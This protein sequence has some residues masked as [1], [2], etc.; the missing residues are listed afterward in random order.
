MN[1]MISDGLSIS[2]NENTWG[3]INYPLIIQSYSGCKAEDAS[4]TSQRS[5]AKSNSI[6][7]V[8]A[9]IVAV[10]LAYCGRLIKDVVSVPLKP[11]ARAYRAIRQ[12]SRYGEYFRRIFRSN[13]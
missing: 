2:P 9:S 6:F 1:P 7:Y 8:P 10:A 12:T 3:L 4:E 11:I 5:V 13:I